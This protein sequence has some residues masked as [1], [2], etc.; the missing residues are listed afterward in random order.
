MFKTLFKPIH[1]YSGGRVYAKEKTED[2]MGV[3]FE[4]E[5]L[6]PFELPEIPSWTMKKEDSLRNFGFEYVLKT[7]RRRKL[8]EKN[9]GMY[10]DTMSESL[11]NMSKLLNSRRTSTHIHFD[12]GLW[13]PIEI[14]NWA[15]VYWLV[16][17][18]LA[19]FCGEERK[20]NHFCLG[21]KDTTGNISNLIRRIKQGN[22]FDS[23]SFHNEYRYA[24]INLA[25][26]LKFGSVEF[27][28]MR[29]LSEPE[30]VWLWIDL[31]AATKA[32]S[33]KFKNPRDLYDKFLNDYSAETFAIE[34]FG[35]DLYTRLLSKINIPFNIAEEIREIFVLL[36]PLML[37]HPDWKFE[38][39][40][41]NEEEQDLFYSKRKKKS[42]WS[43]EVYIQ[44]AAAGTTLHS[45][46]SLQAVP[47]EIPE[48]TPA[49][50]ENTVIIDDFDDLDDIYNDPFIDEEDDPV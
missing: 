16:E 35:I 14:L 1:E 6:E 19:E 20:G 48:V 34:V 27:R 12:V 3:E 38:Q 23:I 18:L 39:E 24:S 44:Y 13:T 47:P 2:I 29:G 49:T 33:Q 4:N 28:M 32:F 9:I 42:S 31:L 11:G 17:P 5:T 45:L 22:I 26:V 40:L 41:K 36:T 21:A 50:L 15:C 30:T 7:P 43:E 46:G 8:L 25:S 37:L 10:F